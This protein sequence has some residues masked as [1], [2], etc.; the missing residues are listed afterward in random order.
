MTN[1]FKIMKNFEEFLLYFCKI[2]YEKI[3]FLELFS[4]GTFPLP[5]IILI[6]CNIIIINVQWRFHKQKEKELYKYFHM[7]ESLF[8]TTY[9][10]KLQVIHHLR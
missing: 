10:I 9:K 3:I 4:P 6:G 2:K 8:Q 1:K 7:T 5:N